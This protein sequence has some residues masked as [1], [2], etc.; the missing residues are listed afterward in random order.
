[1]QTDDISLTV[2][3]QQKLNTARL[4][5]TASSDGSNSESRH[6]LYLSCYTVV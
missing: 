2:N 4:E 3:I 1:L 5:S 6:K